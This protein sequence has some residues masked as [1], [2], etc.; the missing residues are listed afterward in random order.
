MLKRLW[1]LLRGRTLQSAAP[2]R[3]QP[4]CSADGYTYKSTQATNCAVCGKHKH[5]PLRNDTM[6]GYVCLTCIDQELERLQ[7]ASPQNDRIS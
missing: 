1:N 3:V 5:T 6:G 4:D 2:V 7:A